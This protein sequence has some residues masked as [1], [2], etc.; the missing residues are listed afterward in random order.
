MI[1]SAYKNS[2]VIQTLD[3]YSSVSCLHFKVKNSDGT[4]NKSADIGMRGLVK[5]MDDD[6]WVMFPLL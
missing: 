4:G 5:A 3:G 2:S 6:W 1:A